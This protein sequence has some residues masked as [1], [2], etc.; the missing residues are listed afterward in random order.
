MNLFFFFTLFSTKIHILIKNFGE[1]LVC[2]K[3]S[4]YLC[5][6]FEKQSTA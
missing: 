5:I 1:T 6:A 3:I 4:V 2:F